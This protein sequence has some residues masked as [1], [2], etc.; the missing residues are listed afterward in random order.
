MDRTAIVYSDE[1]AGY[2]FG[3]SHPFRGERF[4]RY[5]KLIREKGLVS[6]PEISL[7]D[8]DAADDRDLL[9]AHSEDYIRRVEILAEGGVPL[10]ADTPLKPAI[11]K[12]ARYIIGAA[13]RAGELVAEGGFRV[14][15][16]VGGGLHHAGRDYG[17][18]FCLFNDVAVCA[19]A[20]I[21]RR[22]LKRVMI[23]DTDAHAG[24][25]T[26]DIFYGEPRV[27]YMSVHQDP[28][29][30]YPGTGFVDQIGA[31]DGEGYTVNVPLPPGADDACMR[32][33]LERVFKPITKEF[34]PDIIIRNGGS[35]PHHRDGLANLGL[36]FMGLKSIGMAVREAATTAGCGIVDLC[37]SGYNPETVAE[38][39]L[40]I[41]SGEIGFDPSIVDEPPEGSLN[42]GLLKV[43]EGVIENLRHELNGY[44]H[45][46]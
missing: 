29:T 44:W 38:G 23:F 26:M 30:I 43:T 11:V 19:R 21:E 8:A 15:Q 27:L 20:L 42:P 18:G 35:D 24:N 45:L 40:S 10:S 7:L 41:L 28:R 46:D 17:G 3:P 39:W 14:G 4:P 16:G 12:A 9:L 22:G 2:D 34:E 33:V 6:R 1:I 37:C 5:M 13:L 31:G 32:L 25:G 36:T